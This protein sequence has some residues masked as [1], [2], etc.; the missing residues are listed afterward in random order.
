MRFGPCLLLLFVGCTRAV[1]SAASSETSVGL[2]ELAAVDPLTRGPLP[3]LLFYPSSAPPGA[4]M[5]LGPY[6]VQAAPGAAP[7]GERWPVVLLSHGHGGSMLGHHDLATGLAQSGFA[8][9][10]VEHVG[11][12]FRDPS[13]FGT[14]RVLL[15][16]PGQLSAA[17]EAALA[18]PGL[19]A[20][21]DATRVGALGFSAG[22]YTALVLGGAVPDL[23]RFDGYCARHAKD[24]E[25]C[26]QKVRRV[27]DRAPTMRD[28]RVK[29]VFAMAPLAH[30]FGPEQLSGLK[31]PV[32][33]VEAA[34]DAVLLPE[35]HARPLREALPNL[36]GF[37]SVDA[38]H[39]VFLAPCPAAM[40]RR[41][42]ELCE[43]AAAVD[44]GAIHRALL[45]QARR[46]FAKSL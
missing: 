15:G 39:Y 32:F 8:V 6:Q 22:G 41:V 7:A 30:L 45:E 9:V 38:G 25:L 17:L 19:G 1:P 10:S 42:P 13:G 4:G 21:L 40:A 20:R 27:L 14:D 34:Q 44:R 46:F 37:E 16:R 26:G 3:A 29:A 35:E 2:R 43:D 18:E 11:D 36:A 23:S 31:A 33:L 28:P 24:A 5:A 12:S